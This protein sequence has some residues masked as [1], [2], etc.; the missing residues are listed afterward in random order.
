LI[1]E[2][3]GALATILLH[4]PPPQKKKKKK[5]RKKQSEDEQCRDE[6]LQFISNLQL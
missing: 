5:Q 1:S 6:V 2:T 4:P 3:N